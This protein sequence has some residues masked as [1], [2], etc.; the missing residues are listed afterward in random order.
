MAKA[1]C[2]RTGHPRERPVKR[3]DRVLGPY[4]VIGSTLC[5][6]LDPLSAPR[7]TR[8]LAGLCEELTASET[9][10][11]G[12]DLTLRYSVKDALGIA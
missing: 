5:V 4:E 8:A 3:R 12:T 6:R 2:S 11:L 9:T 7:R 10:Y 1:G